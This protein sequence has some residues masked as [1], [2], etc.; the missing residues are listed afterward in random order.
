MTTQRPTT[1]LTPAQRPTRQL[2][3]GPLGGL[4]AAGVG[5]VIT[6]SSMAGELTIPLRW[7]CAA[8][9]VAS[10]CVLAS[11]VE[12]RVYV[13]AAGRHPVLR[14]L[15]GLLVPAVAAAVALLG[16]GPVRSALSRVGDPYV[17]ALFVFA[18]FG[19]MAS[20]A[21]GSLI[22]I[23]LD[24]VI[25]FLV[26]DLRSRITL[27]VLGLVTLV[28]GFTVGLERAVPVLAADVQ[29][30]Q[31]TFAAQLGAMAL[32]PH[33]IQLLLSPPTTTILPS[34]WAG[35]A[36]PTVNKYLR[37]S[38]HVGSFTLLF[39]ALAGLIGLPSVLSACHKLADA[40]MER[41]HP[42]RRAFQLLAKGR[43]DVRVEEAGSRDFVVLNRHF[44][45]MVESLG[46]ARQA[47]RAFGLYVS[48]QVLERIRG[49]HGEVVI[50][51]S[52]R[53]ATVFF[54]DIRGFTT[55]SERLAPA[56]VLS[57]LN[58]YFEHVV[59]VVEEH[60]GYLDKFVGD[61]MV[62]V[63]NGPIDQPDHVERAV[64]CAI[65]LQKEID[66][67]NAADVFPEAGKIEVGIG[68]ATGQLVAGNLGSAR[69]ME[70]TVIG[71]TV[72]LAS[73]LTAQAAGGEVWVNDHC[74]QA[75]SEDYPRV[76]LGAIH[77][78]GKEKPVRPFR[79]W[80]LDAPPR[81]ASRAKVS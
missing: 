65:A 72:N 75:L 62:V 36:T 46:Q 18:S 54:A 70:Y 53:E 80:P 13:A 37:T 50:P 39:F 33:E 20:A 2:P 44:N 71:D 1:F 25:S 3:W 4:I 68:I 41:L 60:E 77:V 17:G 69:K 42:L 30:N 61:A 59:P 7:A 8:I 27:A 79:I 66:R 34:D 14:V 47:E 74:A 11:W 26:R 16:A 76:P 67:L 56:Q 58:R 51:A 24:L 35:P 49:Q 43:L 23:L 55:L 31:K 57:V 73:R 12:E 5:V 19:W 81:K 6:A 32:R 10:G 64:Q 21:L 22:V 9:A 29:A 52:L 78:K 63:F 15:F 45:K 48:E 40:T 38:E 28:S